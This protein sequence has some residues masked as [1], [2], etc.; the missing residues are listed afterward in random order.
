[1]IFGILGLILALF[2]VLFVS[3]KTLLAMSK[4]KICMPEKA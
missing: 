2:A 3:Y 1:M 4:G